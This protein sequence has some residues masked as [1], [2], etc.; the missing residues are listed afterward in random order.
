[1]QPDV[2]KILRNL[3]VLSKIKEHDKL[4]TECEHFALHTPTVMRSLYR[5][6]Y[7]EARDQNITRVAECVRLAK[8]SVT[9]I[10]AEYGDKNN[11]D[12]HNMSYQLICHEQL[13]LCTRM[14]SALAESAVGLDNLAQTYRDDTALVVRIYHIKG[15]ILDF[16]RNTQIVAQTSPVMQKLNGV[17]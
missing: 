5:F 4:L 17:T 7:A 6:V 1:M 14:I 8:S 2:E 15:D 12:Y 13:S 9:H 16:L 10:L 3:G 11:A